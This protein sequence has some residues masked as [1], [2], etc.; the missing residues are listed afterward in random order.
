MRI[1][2][3][4]DL[5]I[6]VIPKKKLL[7]SNKKLCSEVSWLPTTSSVLVNSSDALLELAAYQ[8]KNNIVPPVARKAVRRQRATSMLA[9]RLNDD[10]QLN[11]MSGT[12]HARDV[13]SE[14]LA[15]F[16]S[17]NFGLKSSYDRSVNP[18][19][20]QPKSD[21]QKIFEEIKK[22]FDSSSSTSSNRLE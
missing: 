7:P 8:K 18:K 3:L 1:E 16:R 9:D 19:P 20:P 15:K 21:F 14:L 4:A 5:D 10:E 12:K 13:T 2:R 6:P 11:N 17:P 22:R